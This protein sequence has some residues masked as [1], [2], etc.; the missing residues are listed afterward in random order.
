MIEVTFLQVIGI[1]FKGLPEG[2]FRILSRF[3][4]LG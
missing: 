4:S 3:M 2:R 1:L